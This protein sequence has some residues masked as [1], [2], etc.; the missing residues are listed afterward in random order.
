MRYGLIAD[1]HANLP[2]LDA[3]LAALDRAGVDEVLCAGDLV[4]YGPFPDACVERV[5][6]RCSLVVAGNHDLIAI[7]R[8]DTG[9]CDALA[10]QTLDWTREAIGDATRSALEA[11]PLEATAPGGVQM[12]HG[13]PG[14]PERYVRAADEAQALAAALDDGATALVLG[15]THVAA[16]VGERRGAM[17]DSLETVVLPEGERVV[18]NPG[19]IGQSRSRD[20]RARAAVLD[21]ERRTVE[22]LAIDFDHAVTRAALRERGLPPWACHRPPARFPGQYRLRRMLGR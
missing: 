11:L 21:L 18:V 14:D 5:L 16:V 13:A 15:H 22:V 8:L 7:G 6:D 10:R 4:G 19:S 3:A 17:L 1:V 12:T 9:R 2:A 20:P